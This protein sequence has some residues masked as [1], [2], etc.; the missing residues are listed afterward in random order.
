M[1]NAVISHPIL[2]ATFTYASR[3]TLGAWSSETVLDVGVNEPDDNFVS[4]V[5]DELRITMTPTA[6]TEIDRVHITG[7]S[8][9]TGLSFEVVGST[10]LVT[11]AQ[12]VHAYPASTHRQTVRFTAAT[13]TSFQ[14]IIT[15]IGQ[16]ALDIRQIMFAKT[17]FAPNYNFQNESPLNLGTRFKA[18]RS[19]GANHKRIDD[20]TRNEVMNFALMADDDYKKLDYMIRQLTLDGFCLIETD[21][22][23]DDHEDS[24]LGYIQLGQISRSHTDIKEFNLTLTEKYAQ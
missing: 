6:S 2:D 18:M 5:C 21:S 10:S 12:N 7:L 14:L 22:V 11:D 20:S 3:A 8:I 23:S 9:L 1:A 17:Y 15:G 19:K 16:A 13:H 24:Y 4:P